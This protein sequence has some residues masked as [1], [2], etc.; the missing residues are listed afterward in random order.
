MATWT[1]RAA[2]SGTSSRAKGNYLRE[3]APLATGGEEDPF[4]RHVIPLFERAAD[5]AI[6]AAFRRGARI[7]V[8]TGDYLNITQADALEF[9]ERFAARVRRPSDAAGH[10]RGFIVRNVR[11]TAGRLCACG[12]WLDHWYNETRSR[13]TMCAVLGCANDVA[14]GAHVHE[15]TTKRGANWE[16]FIVPLCQPCNMSRDDLLVDVRI[17]LVSANTQLMGCYLSP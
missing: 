3:I 16:Q 14:V 13:R 17:E 1:T 8:I 12:S 9:A 4:A 15:L 2:A 6:V 5:I 10:G 11:G 7:R